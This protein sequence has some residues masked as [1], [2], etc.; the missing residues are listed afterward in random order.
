[1]RCPHCDVGIHEDFEVR[2]AFIMVGG[3]N[4]RAKYQFCPECE[5][6][7][8]RLLAFDQAGGEYGRQIP[9]F[10]AYPQNVYTRP[11]P[12]EVPDPYRQDF[13][14]AVAVLS[15][16]PKAS[17]ALS[18]RNLQAIIHD[19]AGIK[20]KDLNDEIEKLIATGIP[21]FV[22]E[23]LHAVRHIGNFAAHPIKSKSTG[24]IVDVEEGEAEWN[25]DALESLFDFYFVQPAITS[26]K[27]AKLNEKL[28]AAGKPTLPIK[29]PEAVKPH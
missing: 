10:L 4:W 16:S 18:R 2:T 27:K 28:L 22:E 11:A 20:G 13:V 7:I 29:D 26:K 8:V 19:K 3:L 21:S 9:E 25:L 15:I 23:G 12:A 5:N 14:E 6:P 17:A 1:M 24:E